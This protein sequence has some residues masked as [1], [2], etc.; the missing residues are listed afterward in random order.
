MVTTYSLEK[1]CSVWKKLLASVE[2][3]CSDKKC[4]QSLRQLEPGVGEGG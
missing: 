4:L 3:S 1:T 2:L